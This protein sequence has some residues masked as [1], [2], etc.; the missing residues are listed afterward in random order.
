MWN[1]ISELVNFGISFI[2]TYKMDS[3]GCSTDLV[4]NYLAI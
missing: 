4:M 1:G 3:G 2:K